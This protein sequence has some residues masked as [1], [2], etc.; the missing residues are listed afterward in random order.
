MVN[1]FGFVFEFEKGD[2]WMSD[3]YCKLVCMSLEV[4]NFYEVN[5]LIIA[6][7]FS[8]S[9]AWWGGGLCKTPLSYDFVE[10]SVATHSQGVRV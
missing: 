5:R 3:N 8:S 4:A 6:L 10:R 9:A 7:F 2:N 1:S